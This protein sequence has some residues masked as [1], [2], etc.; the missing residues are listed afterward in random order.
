MNLISIGRSISIYQLLCKS[1][2]RYI[3]NNLEWNWIFFLHC[4]T[5]YRQ[6]DIGLELYKTKDLFLH[7]VSPTIIVILT[8]IQVH[9]FH[10]RFIAS[11]NQPTEATSRLAD[12]RHKSR[13]YSRVNESEG[14]EF[15][16]SAGNLIKLFLIRCRNKAEVFF[17]HFKGVFWRLLELHWI[18][19]VY[20]T[21]FICAVSEVI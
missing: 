15:V 16:E 8:V 21:A 20:I 17:K 5:Y 14:M 18:K 3:L 7:L 6:T 2:F 1:F 12:V 11:I 13:T 4:Y 19:V 9:Y 10:K